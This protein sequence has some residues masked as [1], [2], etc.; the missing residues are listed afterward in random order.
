MK[1]DYTLFIIGLIVCFGLGFLV[2]G[3]YYSG[4]GEASWG[5]A[6]TVSE[7]IGTDVMNHQ[8]EAFGKVNDFVIDTNG[9]VPFAV[10]SY[11][12]KLV[13]I[14]FGTLTYS[15]EGKHLVLDLSREKLDSAPTFDKSVLADRKWIEDAYRYFG[16]TPYWTTGQMQNPAE[17]PSSG[18]AEP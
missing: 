6:Y 8:G 7:I 2:A 10:L 5:R 9:K 11:G 4:K 12:E 3:I 14:P 13:A 17:I 18:Y 1:K 15:T 16:Q